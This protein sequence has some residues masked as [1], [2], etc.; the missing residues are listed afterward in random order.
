M[1][2]YED[3]LAKSK[4]WRD[5]YYA[6]RHTNNLSNQTTSHYPSRINALTK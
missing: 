1:H 4:E 5:W 3:L 2:N 6:E